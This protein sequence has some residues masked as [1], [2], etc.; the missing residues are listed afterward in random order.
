[1]NTNID[2]DSSAPVLLIKTGTSEFA[3]GTPGHPDGWS[4]VNPAHALPL[5]RLFGDPSGATASGA[6]VRY[7]TARPADLPI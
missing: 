1:M 5:L 7:F 4:P 6:S 2:P 3:A